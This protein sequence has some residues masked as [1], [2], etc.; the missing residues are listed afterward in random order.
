MPSLL[1]DLFTA[2]GMASMSALTFAWVMWM[3]GRQYRQQGMVLAIASTLLLGGAY[4]FWALQSRWNTAPLHIAS[5]VLI[6][7]A[8]GV[9]TVALLRFNH[10][11]VTRHDAVI[12]GLPLVASLLLTAGWLPHEL[13]RFQLLQAGL[14]TLQAAFIVVLLL[15]MR[16]HTPGKGW[17]LVAGAAWLQLITIFPLEFLAQSAP[18]NT[19]VAQHSVAEIL[20]LWG[21]VLVILLKLTASCSGFLLMLR[22]R[23]AVMEQGK[24]LLDPLTQLPN[25]TALVQTMQTAISEAARQKQPLSIMV[26]DIDHFKNV[27]D[28]YGHLVGDSV[29]QSI[30]RILVQQAR[31][32]DFSCRYGGEEFVVV[33]P[34]TNAREAFHLADRLCQTVRKSPVPLPNGKLL[35]TTVSIGVHA[36]APAHG[37]SWKHLVSA[38]DEAMYVAKRNGRDRVTMSASVHA[39]RPRA[40][41][42]MT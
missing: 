8:M 1:P 35:H 9:F 21:V 2:Y 32:G 12:V 6:N 37:S 18:P 25:R 4:A 10:H 19:L 34:N 26:L 41:A 14:L 11:R 39:M 5:H 28:S 29:I 17:R 33:L 42:A 27:N 15:R 30:A 31:P 20:S 7:A 36:G 22:D 3:L 16:R 13:A 38:A 24:A 23:A 40:E